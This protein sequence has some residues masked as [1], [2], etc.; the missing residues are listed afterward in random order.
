MNTWS[1]GL[2]K[3][4]RSLDSNLAA[5]PKIFVAQAVCDGD[6]CDETQRTHEESINEFVGDEFAGKHANAEAVRWAEHDLRLGSF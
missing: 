3:L 5:G 4:C 6:E 2:G 1:T